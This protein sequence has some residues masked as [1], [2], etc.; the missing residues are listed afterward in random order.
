MDIEFTSQEEL[1]KRV[2]PALTSKKR[3]LK[4]YGYDISEQQIWTY[5]ATCIFSQ[6]NNLVLA[7]IV[8]S[9]MHLDIEDLKNFLD[10]NSK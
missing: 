3:E 8:S 1:Y 2:R 4:R 7:D 9:I 5:L 10:K 6:G